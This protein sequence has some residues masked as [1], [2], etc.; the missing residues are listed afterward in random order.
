MSKI[1]V[2]EIPENAISPGGKNAIGVRV[3]GHIVATCIG[4]GPTMRD[5]HAAAIRNARAVLRGVRALAA[6]PPAP[7]SV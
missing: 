5:A 6:V 4:S 2:F 3:D 7:T 1:E